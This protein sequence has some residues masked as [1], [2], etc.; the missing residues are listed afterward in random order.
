MLSLIEIV[1]QRFLRVLIFVCVRNILLK[2]GLPFYLNNF[3][4]SLPNMLCAKISWNW[5]SGS[6][7]DISVVIVQ[8]LCH[9]FLPLEDSVAIHLKK[10]ESSSPRMLCIKFGWN[11]PCGSKEE[12]N[13]LKNKKAYKTMTITINKSRSKKFIW[14]FGSGELIKKMGK[15]QFWRVNQSTWNKSIF[16][17]ASPGKE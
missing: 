10:L 3:K 7:E 17:G 16:W 2:N 5:P 1:W 14:A 15:G 4:S 13:M 9:N 11:W 6:E 12:D 8:W